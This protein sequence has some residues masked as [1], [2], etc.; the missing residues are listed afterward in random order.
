L[1]SIYLSMVETEEEKDLVTELYN[2][3]KQILF[4]VSMS[5]LHNTADAEDA[6]QETF[7]RIISNLSKIDCANE[8]RSKAYIF[9]V[10]RNICYDILRKKHKVVFLED[11]RELVDTN[12]V[13][14]TEILTVQNNIKMLSPLLK[15]VSTLYYAEEFTVEQISGMLDISAESVYKAI[16]RARNILLQKQGDMKND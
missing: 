8:K 4:N 5:I 14:N 13:D 11:D 7:V 9:V 3:Y 12:A 6:V 1:L 16:S 2:T 15:N 10:T